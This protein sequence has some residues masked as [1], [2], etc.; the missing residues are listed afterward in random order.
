MK[1]KH[2]TKKQKKSSRYYSSQQGLRNM[3]RYKN[4]RPE[5]RGLSRVKRGY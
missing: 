3:Q 4:A 1:T 2:Y 5:S